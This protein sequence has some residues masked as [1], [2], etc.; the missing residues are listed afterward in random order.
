MSSQQSLILII[1]FL[2]TFIIIA[3]FL[4]VYYSTAKVE[5]TEGLAKANQKRLIFFIILATV[6]A[7]LTSVT[8]QKSPYFLYKNENPEK[9][10]FV[11]AR[12]YSFTMAYE[13]IKPDEA[14]ATVSIEVP[15]D[16]VVE[17]RVTS[18]DVNHGFAI[19]ND[20]GQL[21]AQTQAMPGYTNILR[22][23]FEEVGSYNILC[24]EY[25]GMAHANMRASFT[26]TSN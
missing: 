7:I 4:L 22:W 25:C 10:V 21:I 20:K 19:Y 1:F 18:F 24:L 8:L 16:K 14:V 12:Q 23:K 6:A 15:L 3:V 11:A 13:N 9:V 17:F 5:G 2:V 26:V